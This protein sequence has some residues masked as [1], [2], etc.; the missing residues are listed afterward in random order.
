MLGV[1]LGLAFLLVHL[2]GCV[3]MGPGPAK[4]LRTATDRCQQGDDEACQVMAQISAAYSPSSMGG[5]GY[6][7]PVY[8]VGPR[9]GWGW[10]NGPSPVNMSVPVQMT[11]IGQ[12]MH[13]GY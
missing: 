13:W 3:M 10:T 8:T 12:G 6:T 7:A 2:T 5:G 4:A 1:L 9:Y 11:P